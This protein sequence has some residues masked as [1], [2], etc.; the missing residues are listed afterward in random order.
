M[1]RLLIIAALLLTSGVCYS[2]SN[3]DIRKKFEENKKNM[4]DDF[5]ATADKF[6]REFDE[7][8]K[9]IVAEYNNYVKKI[10]GKWGKEN[11]TMSDRDKWVEY[12]SGDNTRSVVDF[13][14]GVA[15]VQTVLSD[16]ELADI[17]LVAKRLQEGVNKL[18]S[19]KGQSVD[20]DSKYIPKTPLAKNPIM[21][22]MLAVVTEKR[23]NKPQATT[24]NKEQYAVKPKVKNNKSAAKGEAKSV[25]YGAMSAPPKSEGIKNSDKSDGNDEAVKAIIKEGKPTI[26]QSVTGD[27]KKVN[28]VTIE[29]PLVKNHL[30]VSAQ[31]Y[32]EAVTKNAKRFGVDATLIF[33]VMEQESH[34]NP[35]AKSYIPAYGLMQIV[36]K[37]AGRD[38]YK[39]IY[40]EDKLLTQDYLFTPDKNIEIGVAYLKILHDRYFKKITD[41][42]CRELCMIA[43]YNTGAGNVSRAFT[44]N[45]NIYKAIPEINKLNYEQLYNH[46]KSKLPYKE[47]QDYIVKVTTKREKYK[48]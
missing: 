16:E 13:K 29:T 4:Q 38:A 17:E 40:K 10:E 19:T 14:E 3:D 18:L 24:V 6:S 26:T 23:D 28:I 7:Y 34:F 21:N 41:A 27:G 11:A 30:S 43:A 36:P 35:K 1:K 33:G 31:R 42:K 45:T 39:Y 9:K 37:Y 47:T 2:Q 46:L 15:K 32:H 8:Q 25:K 5:K 20:Y 48:Q 12:S 44:G 22:D